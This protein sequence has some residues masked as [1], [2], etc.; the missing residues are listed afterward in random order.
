[1]TIP[2]TILTGYLGAGK[3]TLLNRILSEDHGRR[4]AV[5]VNEF[6]EIGIDAELIVAAQENLRQLANGCLCCSVRGDLVETIGEVL[7]GSEPVDGIIVECTGLADPVPVAQ[8]FL[9]EDSIRARTRLD[10]VVTMVD[11]QHFSKARATARELDDQVAFADVLILNKI[12]AVPHSDVQ[13]VRDLLTMINPRAELHLTQRGQGPLDVLLD[14]RAHDL[15]RVGSSEVAHQDA[16]GHICDAGCAH[17]H[18]IAE[19][20]HHAID[21]MSVSLSTDELD[22]ARFFAW[23]EDVTLVCARNLRP[24]GCPPL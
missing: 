24:T 22:P 12:D 9:A 1:M 7:S 18:H 5:I 14:R 19:G 10:A 6:G 23:I 20:G 21:M 4:Y 13:S 2:V 11:A 8:T 16:L 17:H 15:F 3:T